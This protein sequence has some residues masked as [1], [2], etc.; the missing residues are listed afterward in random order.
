MCGMTFENARLILE[1]TAKC[2][3]ENI[4]KTVRESPRVKHDVKEVREETPELSF[5]TVDNQ[6]AVCGKIGHSANRC[7]R[8][9][10]IPKEE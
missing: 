3:K 10:K 9:N 6:C 2:N 7:Y 4:K 5:A 1:K 8:R